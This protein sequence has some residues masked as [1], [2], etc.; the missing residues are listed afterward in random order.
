MHHTPHTQPANRPV[1][2]VLSAGVTIEEMFQRALEREHGAHPQHEG[3][4]E[5]VARLGSIRVDLAPER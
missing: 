3:M 2:A 1:P 4:A 5:L